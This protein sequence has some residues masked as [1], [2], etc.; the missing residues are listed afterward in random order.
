MSEHYGLSKT[1]NQ[2]PLNSKIS[3]L[4]VPKL[5]SKQKEQLLMKSKVSVSETQL[6]IPKMIIS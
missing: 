1:M 6:K 2:S 3:K 5:I 4:P